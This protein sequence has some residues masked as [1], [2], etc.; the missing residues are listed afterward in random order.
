MVVIMAV[1][2]IDKNNLSDGN[3]VCHSLKK[4]IS[5]Y[6]FGY[7]IENALQTRF[8]TTVSYQEWIVL[9]TRK[10]L[11]NDGALVYACQWR[12]EPR[13]RDARGATL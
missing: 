9:A 11:A 10:R 2:I 3:Y 4:K 6:V 7:L 8:L 12:P 1:I 13:R 5:T